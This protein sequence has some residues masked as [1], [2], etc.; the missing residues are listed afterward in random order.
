MMQE[1]EQLSLFDSIEKKDSSNIIKEIKQK[2]KENKIDKL[3]E[4]NFDNKSCTFTEIKNKLSSCKEYKDYIT[5]LFYETSK[6]FKVVEN[7]YDEFFSGRKEILISLS[8][9]RDCIILATYKSVGPI[10]SIKMLE[11]SLKGISK[12]EGGKR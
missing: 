8:N 3:Y 11:N 9:T 6:Y 5:K 1:I 12:I 10:Y 4:R 2:F 7:A